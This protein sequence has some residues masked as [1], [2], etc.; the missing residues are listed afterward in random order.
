MVGM[1]INNNWISVDDAMPQKNEQVLVFTDNELM[2]ISEFDAG[3]YVAGAV[4]GYE[5]EI[6][7]K[8]THW[9]RLPK[10]P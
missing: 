3:W 2:A 1:R 8:V 4:D 10:H 7:G 5:A 6:Y 9:M